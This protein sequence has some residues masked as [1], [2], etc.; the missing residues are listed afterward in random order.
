MR[1]IYWT[2]AEDK[3]LLAS[4]RLGLEWSRIVEDYFPHRTIAS[5]ANRY[6]ALT[7]V[8]TSEF[9]SNAPQEVIVAKAV[10]NGSD[11]LW[12][13]TNAY[14]EREAA[15]R[16]MTVMDT[17]LTILHGEDFVARARAGVQARIA[18]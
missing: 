12:H 17:A 8:S 14:Y 9:A 3:L 5:L 2:E 16:G 1:G 4:R 15:K 7:S 11:A 13:A 10:R 18:A 6:S